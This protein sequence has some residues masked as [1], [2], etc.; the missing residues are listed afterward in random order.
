MTEN[1]KKN[2]VIQNLKIIKLMK[3]CGYTDRD[4]AEKIG[5]TVKSFLE[6]IDEDEYL[7]EVYEH[8]Q[9]KIASEIEEKFV[10]QIIESLEVGKTDDAKWYLQKVKSKFG[11]D[12]SITV[13]IKTIDDIIREHDGDKRE[14]ESGE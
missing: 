8:A 12:N 9:D 5:L 11:K 7:H 13:N 10:N 3:S 2:V 1:E 14:D 6:I 4:I